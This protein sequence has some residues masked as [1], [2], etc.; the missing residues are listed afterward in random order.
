VIVVSNNAHF[1]ARPTS[2]VE[3][4]R[5]ADDLLRK[6]GAA[7]VL[8]TPVDQM[9]ETAKIS[10][11]IS[12]EE[13]SESFF[14]GLKESAR[15]TFKGIMQKIRGV[16]DLRKRAI[17]IQQSDKPPRVLFTK[18]HELGHQQIPWHTVDPTY[19]DDDATLSPNIQ[20]EFEKEASFFASDLMFQGKRFRKRALDY[21]PSF[22]AVFELA[23]LHGAS[24]HATIWRYIEEHD[25]ALAV[26]LYYPVNSF[27]DHNRQV[28]SLWKMVSSSKFLEKYGDVELPLLIRTGDP[29]TRAR[30]YQD[31]CQGHDII[32]C[33]QEKVSFEWHVWWN[34]YTLFVLLRRRPSLGIIGRIMG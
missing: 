23:T 33:G 1:A 15:D 4:S 10:D 5:I 16:A 21:T 26:A 19:L 2:E 13:C 32:L 14:S 7:G 25:E 9:L 8:P 24:R 34:S 20:T 29:W 30:D 22:D 12:I 17:Y 3:I 27:D 28:L 31:I 11:V 18:L 6:A